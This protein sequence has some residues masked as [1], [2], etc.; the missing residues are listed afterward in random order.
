VPG[1]LGVLLAGI[2]AVIWR[3]FW[4]RARRAVAG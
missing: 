4:G 3:S 1:A 2:A